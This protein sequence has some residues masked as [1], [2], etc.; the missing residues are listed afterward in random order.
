LGVLRVHQK[1]EARMSRTRPL[2]RTVIHIWTEEDPQAT[3]LVDLA[4]EATEGNAYCDYQNTE[5]IESPVA[6]GLQTSF[7]DDPDS[8]D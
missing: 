5:Y 7:F 1:G 3:E 2:W 4:R 8:V 6:A